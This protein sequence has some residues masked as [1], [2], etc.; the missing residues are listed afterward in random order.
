MHS[1]QVGPTQQIVERP[2]SPPADLLVRLGAAHHEVLASV[3]LMERVTSAHVPDIELL[4]SARLKTSQANLA[5]R[6]LWHTIRKLLLPKVASTDAAALQR[7]AEM[8]FRLFEASSAHISRWTVQAILA[9][10]PEYQIA[11]RRIRAQMMEAIKAEQSLLYP[12]LN[13]HR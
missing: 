8:D 9:D 6:A 11:S 4:T 3:E 2:I 1:L 12:M 13:A 10:W 7:L 5:R